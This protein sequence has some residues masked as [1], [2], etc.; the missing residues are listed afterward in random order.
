MADNKQPIII[1]KKKAGHAGGHGGAWKVAYAD[2]VTA[3]MA[4]FL[5][6]WICQMDVKTRLGIAEYFTNPSAYGP[7]SPSSWFT[8]KF[9]GVPKLTQGNLEQSKEQGGDPASEGLLRIDP[10]ASDNF[11]QDVA[12]R[13]AAV[14]M[15]AIENDPGFAE[16]KDNVILELTPEGL[17]IELLE[18]TRPRYFS[19]GTAM[20]LGSGRRLAEFLASLLV[21]VQRVI[22]FEGHTTAKPETRGIATKWELGSDRALALRQVFSMSGLTPDQVKAV[23]SRGDQQPRFTDRNDP[24]NLRVAL[25]VPYST[26]DVKIRL[27]R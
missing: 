17:R 6:M 19:P 9:G 13:Y 3:L 5:V 10:L 8:L 26:Q 14:I 22:T 27:P 2:M 4:F 18:S 11:T 16:Y 23:E 1:K 24:R 12:K 15:T 20:W 7:N 25:L 21:P